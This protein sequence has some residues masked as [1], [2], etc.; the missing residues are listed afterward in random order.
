MSLSLN[1][2]NYQQTLSSQSSLVHYI[3]Q[4]QSSL[5]YNSNNNY[6]NN[7]NNFNSYNHLQ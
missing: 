4:H 1:M 5:H 7:N 2:N 3:G 6:S